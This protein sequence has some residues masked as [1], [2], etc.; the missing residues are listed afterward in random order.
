MSSEFPHQ[1]ERI[2]A[3]VPTANDVSVRNHVPHDHSISIPALAGAFTPGNPGWQRFPEKL[4]RLLDRAEAESFQHI[5]SWQPHGR[6]FAIHDREA[7]KEMLPVLM[8]GITLWK[9]F[10]R[11]LHLWGFTRLTEGLDMNCYYHQ[12]FL[13]YRPHLLRH[14]RRGFHGDQTRNRENVEMVPNFYVMPFLAP[15]LAISGIVSN[16]SLEA[17]TSVSEFPDSMCNEFVPLDHSVSVSTSAHSTAVALNL[18]NGTCYSSIGTTSQ[19]AGEE[20]RS[21]LAVQEPRASDYLAQ[22]MASQPS[23]VQQGTTHDR[24]ADLND[25]LDPSPLPP[26]IVW[27]G[28]AASC[29]DTPIPIMQHPG[30]AQTGPHQWSWV[31]PNQQNFEASR[32]SPEQERP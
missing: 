7:F 10:Q 27:D 4:Y 31:D 8:P 29:S 25:E 5:I 16:T 11:Q 23:S 30:F 15:T 28:E 19:A 24:A 26:V 32:E 12:M 1:E 18:G 3:G 20:S 13:R 22:I 21:T 17:T 2:P 9:S 14:L 6:C